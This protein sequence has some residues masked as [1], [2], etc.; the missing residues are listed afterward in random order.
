MAGHQANVGPSDPIGPSAH[1]CDHSG[2]PGAVHCLARETDP[3]LQPTY[4][5]LA[6]ATVTDG[7]GKA[8]QRLDR[9]PEALHRGAR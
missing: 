5:Q 2:C 3:Y 4:S 8:V 1:Q 9:G 7:G 6:K